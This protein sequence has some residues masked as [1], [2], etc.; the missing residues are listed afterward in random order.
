MICPFCGKENP[1]SAPKCQR[2]G[3]SFHTEPLIA[4][5][6]PPRKKHWTPW[7]IPLVAVGVFCIIVLVILLSQS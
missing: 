1:T 6:L 2:C 3:V 5:A 7:I 4:D